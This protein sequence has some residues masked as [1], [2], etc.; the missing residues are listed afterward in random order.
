[1]CPL[2]RV[3]AGLRRVGDV[4]F[5]SL[6]ID[7]TAADVLGPAAALDAQ[8]RGRVADALRGVADRDGDRQRVSVCC[9][10]SGRVGQGLSVTVERARR[11]PTA[12]EHPWST[13]HIKMDD[14]R[15]RR[16]PPGT[17]KPQVSEV[18]TCG[19]VVRRQGRVCPDSSSLRVISRQPVPSAA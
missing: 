5:E 7:E 19:A 16:R 8:R 9:Q 11:L 4:T 17:A 3:V 2:V 18:L 15:D 6:I 1:M 13:Q 12:E 14:Q 10:S